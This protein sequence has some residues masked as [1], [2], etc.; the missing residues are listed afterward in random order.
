MM[1]WLEPWGQGNGVSTATHDSLSSVLGTRARLTVEP[2]IYYTF[3]DLE[4]GA[5][6]IRQP[7]PD[8]MIDVI[9]KYE[10]LSRY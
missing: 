2:W 8:R 6:A 7:F 9:A 4:C 5:R 10:R 1:P 3:E